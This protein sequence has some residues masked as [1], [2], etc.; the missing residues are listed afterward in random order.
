MFDLLADNIPLYP[1]I[2]YKFSFIS[3]FLD[4]LSYL[5]NILFALALFTFTL[6]VIFDP[7]EGLPLLTTYCYKIW[8]LN[9]LFLG[10]LSS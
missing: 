6:P 5:L 8:E 2:F 7:I 10:L 9:I 3:L 1:L 4:P